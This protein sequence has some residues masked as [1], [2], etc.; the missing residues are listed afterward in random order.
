MLR[1]RIATGLVLGVAVTA[2]LLLLPTRAAAGILGLLWIVGAWEWAGLAGLNVRGRVV[3]AGCFAAAMLAVLLAGATSAVSYAAFALAILGWAAAFLGVLT[4]PREFSAPLVLAA[5]VVALWPAWVLLVALHSFG[6]RGPAL[7]LTALALVGAADVGAYFVGRAV[8]RLKLAPRVSPGKTWEGV[9][10]GV[11]FA[12]AVAWAASAL[13]GLSPAPLVAVGIATALV[14]VV[15]DL[16]VS[17]LKRNRGLKDAG[18]LLPGHGG[19]MDRIDGLVAA[20]PFFA[21][22]LHLTG[23]AF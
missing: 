23:I 14:S 3:Y 9:T 17:M 11:L 8:G 21:L 12:V 4:Y 18:R 2:A 6:G 5:G 19:V 16:T 20:I 7:A 1:A 15:G 22:G 10:G 13:L